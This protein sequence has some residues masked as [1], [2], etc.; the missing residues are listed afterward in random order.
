MSG[1]TFRKNLVFE[2]KHLVFRIERLLPN[3]DALLEKMNDGSYIIANTKQLLSSYVNGEITTSLSKE[4]D[5]GMNSPSFGRPLDELPPALLAEVKRRKFY[6]DK[7]LNLDQRNF[8]NDYLRPILTSFATEI[9]DKAPPSV[10]SVYRWYKKFIVDHDIRAL[11]PRF[12]HRGGKKS[13]QSSEVLELISIA[14]AESFKASPQAN[15]GAIYS[16]L[17]SK[18]QAKNR[19]LLPSDQ[20][21]IP[22]KRTLYRMLEKFDRYDLE[23][24]KHGEKAADKKLRS[25][26][27]GVTTS[28]I[29]ERVEVDHTPL[30]LFLIDEVT[31]LPLGR[32]TLTVLID[33]YSRML[34]GFHLSFG[35]PSASAVIGALRHAILPKTPYKELFSQTR[36]KN[37][38]PCYGRPDVLV[39]DNG[40]EFH[41]ADLENIALDLGIEIR[42]CP[43][44][45]PRFKGVVERFLKTVNYSFVSQIPG[46]SFARWHM[47]GDYSPEKHALITLAEFNQIFEKWVVDIYAQDVHRGIGATPWN[48]WHE[49]LRF[50]EPEL[51]NDINALKSRI[52]KVSERSLRNDGINVN[53]I[54]YNDQSL[55]PIIRRYGEGVKVRVLFDPENLGEIHVWGPE[56]NDPI[57]VQALN[58]SYANG[59]TEFQNNVIRANQ[60]ESN[61]SSESFKSVQDAKSEINQL[62]DELLDSRK[63]S[64]RRLGARI[65][66]ESNTKSKETTVPVPKSD[67]STARSKLKV[68]KNTTPPD[69][70][71]P[72]RIAMPGGLL[73]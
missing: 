73:K 19:Q 51:P 53:G 46:A 1:F 57:T 64:H 29:L 3:N 21:T 25:I 2:W 26:K 56:R 27:S 17:F 70:L 52:G 14:I 38:W 36:T 23:V 11:V 65:R 55:L 24:L 54:R 72:F 66:G 50:R 71:Q 62:V 63:Q 44:H 20:L 67:V 68:E 34:L 6:V 39:V 49:G 15:C 60:R 37:S 41:G 16:R 40:L 48:K 69:N 4:G 45:A 28:R 43:K 58:F 59:L 10:T 33:H 12:D 9:G 30:D 22:S 5:F 7:F 18:I 42:Y 8:R 61:S 13:K 31:H 35:T 32:P 47:R